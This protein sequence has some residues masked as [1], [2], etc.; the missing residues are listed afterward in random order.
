VSGASLSF[1][2][3]HDATPTLDGPRRLRF[4]DALP[5]EMQSDAWARESEKLEGQ[6]VGKGELS[7]RRPRR[8]LPVNNQKRS[9]RSNVTPLRPDRVE[10]SMLTIPAPSYFEALAGI[11]VSDNGGTV[12]CPSPRHDDRSP[13]CRV[14]PGDRGWHCFGC[15][16]GGSIYDLASELSGIGTRGAEFRRLREWIAQRILNAPLQVAA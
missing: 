13:S 1:G 11:A 12:N 7:L 16:R 6:R 2:R 8:A 15:G 9:S 3:L 5:A 4:F 14:Y 10:D